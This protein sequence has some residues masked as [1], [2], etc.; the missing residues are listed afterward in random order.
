MLKPPAMVYY[1]CMISIKFKFISIVILVW[2]FF[3][4]FLFH[5]KLQKRHYQTPFGPPRPLLRI[6]V[7]DSGVARRIDLHQ[8]D[9]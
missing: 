3:F 6:L 5:K 2:D 9:A 1:N 7:I 8:I 4:S